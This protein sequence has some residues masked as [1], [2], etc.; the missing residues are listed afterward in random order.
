MGD[1]EGGTYQLYITERQDV[2]DTSKGFDGHGVA[3]HVNG[4]SFNGHFLQGKRS[5]YGTYV[6]A[7]NGDE[8]SGQYA[9]NL[10]SGLGKFKYSDQREN[11]EDPPRGGSYHGEW[12]RNTRDGNG[13][14]TYLNMDSYSGQWSNGNKHGRG[15]YRYSK[16]GAT[17][18][19]R[20]ENNYFVQ[21]RW[22]L[23]NGVFYVGSFKWNHPIGEGCWVFP[24]GNQLQGSFTQIEEREEEEPPEDEEAIPEI[25]PPKSVQVTW[26][27]GKATVVHG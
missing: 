24:G 27:S 15:T 9:D 21:G 23:A 6:W 8:Y 4:D 22:T 18:S 20:W 19:G 2:Q 25:K 10:R 26:Q 3:S 1:E 11:E 14:F 5:G 7:K 13:T 16:D 12:S 17:L